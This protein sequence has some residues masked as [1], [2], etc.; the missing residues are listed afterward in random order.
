M[1]NTDLTKEQLLEQI[2]A[3][4]NRIFNLEKTLSAKSQ[5]EIALETSQNNLSAI[6][7]NHADGIVIVNT[8]GIVLYVN[9]AAEK[10]FSRNKA[11]FIGSPFGFPISTEQA[12]NNLTIKNGNSFIEVELRSVQVV[13]HMEPAYQLSIRDITDHKQAEKKMQVLS[14]DLQLI[15]KNM[16]NAFVVWES[17]FDKNGKYVS[18]CFGQFNDSYA[19]I[20]GLKQ[21]DVLGKDVFEVWPTTEQSWV[22]TYGEVAVTGIPKTFDMFHEP[23]NGWYHCNAYRPS[24]STEQICVIFEDITKRRE[25]EEKL[26]RNIKS[27]QQAEVLAHLGNF[28]KNWQTGEEYWSKGFYKLLGIDEKSEALSHKDFTNFVY[29]KDLERVNMHIRKSL[30][31]HKP[32]NIE[33]R[34]VKANGSIVHIHGIADNDYDKDDKPLLTIGVFRDI[35]NQIISQKDLVESEEKFRTLIKSIPLPLCLVNTADEIVFTND[36]FIKIF[37]YTQEDIPTLNDWWLKAYPEKK[38]HDWVLNTWNRA[39]EDARTNKED[40]ESIEYTVTCKNGQTRTIIVSGIILRDGF[41]ATFS[42]ITERKLAEIE[43]K[44]LNKDLEQRVKNRTTE[45]EAANK[46][47]E[48]FNDLFV[49]REFRIKELKEKVKYLEQQINS[50]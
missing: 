48:K 11:D 2:T 33:F 42:D 34:L 4:Q 45:L 40:I 41:L 44:N 3:Q 1:K 20:S 37:G 19:Q 22:K 15:F 8:E 30:I 39:I 31:E 36:R 25:T 35:T 21:E 50:K 24:D 38:Y 16:I 26:K 29:L 46:E 7:E 12:T 5:A 27:L 18:F 17:V 49:G 47:L 23:T 32:M 28:E 6:L 9:P 43:I 10:L 13:W 14:T